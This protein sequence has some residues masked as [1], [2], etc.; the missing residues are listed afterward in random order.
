MTELRD[1]QK[2][3]KQEFLDKKELIAEVTT[4]AGKTFFA[5]DSINEILKSNPEYKVLICVPKIVIL[6]GWLK[7]LNRFFYPNEIGFYYGMIKEY[8]RITITT[9]KSILNVNRKIFKVR[10]FDEIHNMYTKNLLDILNEPCDYKLGLSATI[11]D[12]GN[13]RH[14]K[15]LKAFNYNK[16]VYGMSDAIKDNV[17][18][19]YEFTDY[20]VSIKEPEIKDK[21][22]SIQDNIRFILKKIGGIESYKRLP[23]DNPDKKALH[24]LFDRRNK[25]VLNYDGKYSVLNEILSSNEDKKIIIFNQYNSIG[26]EI[27]MRA[28]DSAHKCRIV[29]S[30]QEDWIKSRNIKD[31]A[32]DKYN[33]MITTKMF[34]EGYNLPSI[35]VA[36]IFSGDSTERQ[37][38][39][40]IGRV[41]R[42]KPTHSKIYQIY[43]TGTF[44]ERHAKKRTDMFK[45][46]A[47]K[48]TECEI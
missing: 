19:N 29:N 30:D 45:D 15:M 2:R 25:L 1:W 4:G 33:V 16:F 46:M 31:F 38:K 17:L 43:V 13:D 40:R 24:K 34:D 36:I 6:N 41:L 20:K 48:Y 42:L 5:A 37:T 8:S 11:R 28:L 21:Y 10:I 18:N 27:Y 47:I 9:T 3:A 14:W 32:D 7:D 39:Q 23:E 26:R 22:Q 12:E 35:D 44:E